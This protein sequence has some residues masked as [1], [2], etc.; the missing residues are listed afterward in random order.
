MRYLELANSNIMFVL[1]AL[2][3][4]RGALEPTAR[5]LRATGALFESHLARQ[6]G[7]NPFSPVILG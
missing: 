4:K 6:P 7:A 1:V 3:G 5:S 2:T